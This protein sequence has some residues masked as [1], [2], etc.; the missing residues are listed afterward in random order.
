LS[1][2]LGCAA[3]TVWIIILIRIWEEIANDTTSSTASLGFFWL[4]VWGFVGLLVIL[5][6][7]GGLLAVCGW[8][9][10]RLAR[11]EV[12]KKGPISN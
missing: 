11:R 1:S 8:A 4:P 2:L 10:E 12:V 7:V 3:I 5:F 9:N 6:P